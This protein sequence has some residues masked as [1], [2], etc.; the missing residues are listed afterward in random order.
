MKK[1]A[2]SAG[3]D[4]L[5][6][7]LGVRVLANELSQAPMFGRVAK[8]SAVTT[9]LSEPAT[10]SPMEEVDLPFR[11]LDKDTPLLSRVQEFIGLSGAQFIVR[12]G[13]APVGQCYQNVM[14]LASKFSGTPALGWMVTELPNLYVQF[15][16]HCVLKMPR[17]MIDVTRPQEPSLPIVG[18]SCFIPDESIELDPN[19]PPL[20][21][22]LHMMLSNDENVIRSLEA[23]HANHSARSALRE[24]YEN[25]RSI[26]ELHKMTAQTLEELQRTSRE[27]HK[28]RLQ[29]LQA[30]FPDRTVSDSSRGD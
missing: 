12:E 22:D 3:G 23:Y 28:Y 24:T 4:A 6:G 8:P 16:H 5:S 29:I 21:E 7:R 11:D 14:T 30:H 19:N 26:A 13:L 17:G 1:P 27:I 15:M 10:R 20:V 9:I 18:T 25:A 2:A